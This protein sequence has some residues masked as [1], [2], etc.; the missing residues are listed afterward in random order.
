MRF[1]A[2]L[3]F[4]IFTAV[5]FAQKADSSGPKSVTVPITLDH[6]RV[7]LDVEL[8]LSDG[9]NQRI[10]AWVDTGTPILYLSRR[11]AGLLGLNV[12]C[13]EKECSAP[14]PREISIGGMTISL[15][16]V[17]EAKIPLEPVNAAA[18]VVRGLPAE[19]SLPSSVLRNYD[20]LIDFPGH[21][22]SIGQPGSLKFDTEKTKITVNADGTVQVPSQIE[23]KKYNLELALGSPIS[24]LTSDLFGNLLSAHPNWPHMTGAVGPANVGGGEDEAKRRLMRVERVQYGPLFL[25]DVVVEESGD[26]TI[27]STSKSAT[28]S[29]GSLG[30]EALLNYRVG[31]DYAH[32]AV[33][34]EIGRTFNIPDFDVVGLTL[35]PEIDGRFTVIAIADFDGKPSVLQGPDGIEDGDSLVAVDDIPTKGASL[36]QVWAMLVGEVGQERRLTMERG[37]K[38]FVLLARVRHFLGETAERS[39]GAR[40]SNKQ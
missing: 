32:S 2:S 6:D 26:A 34:F 25:T 12:T 20:L 7:L 22:L 33:Y 40:N 31:L 35:R 18:V 30:S 11:V 13:N 3:V 8:E 37:G 23:K 5:G 38:Q 10:R 9:S 28:S 17:K 1:A 39:S 16:G 21:K 15:A 36:G 14:P 29:G 4:L 27:A 19:V 24:S